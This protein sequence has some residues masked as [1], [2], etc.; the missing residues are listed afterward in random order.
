[1]GHTRNSIQIKRDIETVFSLTNDI[2]NWSKLFTEYQVS[3][4]IKRESNKVTFQLITYPNKDDSH[5]HSWIS[6]R[7]ID[8]D[9]FQCFATRLSPLFPFKYMHIYWKYLYKNGVTEMIWI[10]DFEL[11]EKCSWSESEFEDY[12]NENS[13]I[14][15]NE[16]KLKIEEY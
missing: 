1:M 3:K 16:I 8:Q 2:A 6:E 11:E 5:Q 13:R 12:L 4:I 9:N 15:M 14:Q 10:Q 7:I